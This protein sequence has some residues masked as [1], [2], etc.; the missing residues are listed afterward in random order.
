MPASGEKIERVELTFRAAPAAARSTLPGG[1][2]LWCLL[3]CVIGIG[4]WLSGRRHLTESLRKQLHEARTS[5]E[6]WL[7]LDGLAKLSPEASLEIVTGLEHPDPVIARTAF[8]RLEGLLSLW[9]TLE[10]QTAA[11][12]YEQLASRL[13]K[14]SSQ[15][16]AENRRLANTLASRLYGVC[17][18]NGSESLVATMELCRALIDRNAG[19]DAEL[20]RL[21]EDV[22]RIAMQVDRS[23]GFQLATASDITASGERAGRLTET[24]TAPRNVFRLSDDSPYVVDGDAD[25]RLHTL[26]SD[27]ESEWDSMGS[28]EQESAS[29]DRQRSG[30]A[31]VSL[32]SGPLQPRNSSSSSMRSADW[33]PPTP[34]P[35][36]PSPSSFDGSVEG[37]AAT[38]MAPVVVASPASLSNTP[39]VRMKVVSVQTDLDGIQH[40]P[41]EE[42]V[43]LLASQD[44]RIAQGA[45]LALKAKGLDDHKLTLASE[46]AGG[47]AARRLEL[48]QRI[49]TDGNFIPDL[50]PQPWLLWMAEDGE[51]EVRRMSVSLLSSM[52]STD[53]ERTLRTLLARERDAHVAEV[54]R[55]ALLAGRSGR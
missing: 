9:Q 11:K 51:P 19:Y 31:T 22:Q 3:G 23:G 30:A 7:A 48:V 50:V 20:Y 21:Q 52:M 15:A 34:T 13:D 27:T 35:A 18:T 17:Y 24:S 49:A 55:Q 5:S 28:G 37:A 25:D 1:W 4:C 6:V 26:G 38:L 53:V 40:L 2:M 54:I 33:G 39:L 29:S 47:T 41:I 14:F 16:P 32:S 42:L 45:A 8:R 10:P 46:L 43:R 36:M 44:A 12:R